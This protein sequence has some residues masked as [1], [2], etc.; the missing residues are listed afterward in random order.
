[1]LIGY[2]HG[3]MDAR[4]C[5]RRHA[6]L[7]DAGCRYTIEEDAPIQDGRRPQLTRILDDLRSDDVI[8]VTRL[9]QLAG[10]GRD[11]LDLADRL[12]SAGAGLRSLAEPWADAA[13][14]AGRT[15]LMLSPSIATFEQALPCPAH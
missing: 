6:A 11:L 14:P 4:E 9:D 1:M 8:V 5:A 12:N 13:S 3:S 10:S 2:I 7:K 15:M